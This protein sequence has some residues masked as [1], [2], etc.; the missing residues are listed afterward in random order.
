MSVIIRLQNLP[1]SANALE[2]RTFFRGLNIPDGGVHIVGGEMGDAFIAFSSDEDA[3]Q[4]MLLD[5]GKIN[6]VQIRLLLSSRSEMQKVIELARQQSL[7]MHKKMLNTQTIAPVVVPQTSKIESDPRLRSRNDDDKRR[8]RRSSRDRSHDRYRSSRSSSNERDY[9]DHRRRDRSRSASRSRRDR[10]RSSRRSRSRDRSRERTSDKLKSGES[11][12]GQSVWDLINKKPEDVNPY[13]NAYSTKAPKSNEIDLTSSPQHESENI[14]GLDG[15]IDKNAINNLK[16]L[17]NS[18]PNL[19]SAGLLSALSSLAKP[20]SPAVPSR[21]ETPITPLPPVI[22]AYQTNDNSSGH[23][24]PIMN[25]IPGRSHQNDKDADNDDRGLSESRYTD[26]E[27]HDKRC[28]RISHMNPKTTYSEVRRYFSGLFIQTNGIKLINDDK[29][30]RLGTAYVKFLRATSTP[31]AL[32][33]DGTMLN[34]WKVKVDVVS[35]TEFDVAIDSYRPANKWHDKPREDEN[36]LGIKHTEDVNYDV[37]VL[38]L[39]DLPAYTNELDIKKAFGTNRNLEI[40]LDR[41]KNS[42]KQYGYVK[43]ENSLELKRA[44][45]SNS[46]PRIG[47]HKIDVRKSTEEEMEQLCKAMDTDVLVLSDL[48]AFSAEQDIM[49]LFNNFSII[50][51]FMTR[52][53]PEGKK[54]YE[55][56]SYIKLSNPSDARKILSNRTYTLSHRIIQ[57]RVSNATEMENAKEAHLQKMAAEEAERKKNEEKLKINIIREKQM[58]SNEVAKLPPQVKL[59]QFNDLPPIVNMAP[60]KPASPIE[61]SDPRLR[62][63]ASGTKKKSRFTEPVQPVIIKQEP[64]PQLAPPPFQ[65]LFIG[66]SNIAYRATIIDIGTYFMENNCSPNRI[67]IIKGPNNLPCGDVVLEMKCMEDIPQ[68]LSL[69]NSNFYNRKISVVPITLNDVVNRLGED[70]LRECE[71]MRSPQ[72]CNPIQQY[73]EQNQQP[74]VNQQAF[75]NGPEFDPRIDPRDEFPRDPRARDPRVVEPRFPSMNNFD[76]GG[77]SNNNNQRRGQN[78]FNND[79]IMETPPEIPNDTPSVTVPDKFN[80]PGRVLVL[81]NVPYSASIEDIA[82]FFGNFDV[83]PEDVIRRYNKDGSPTGDARVA[84]HETYLAEAAF[85]QKN[86]Q[87]LFNRILYL[88]PV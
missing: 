77:N 74:F 21:S 78:P 63:G 5:R 72:S 71:S 37:T 29:G 24:Y 82:R 50:D 8:G 7:S 64:P 1:W 88:S 41:E 51:I 86:R 53:K 70:F 27:I 32:F 17:L 2:I 12:Q 66:L 14:P 67:E 75:I 18:N 38:K 49:K 73:P 52:T 25:D 84:F 39:F 10:H 19:T 79:P 43:F 35:E 22:K 23:S 47:N 62:N 30:D 36:N 26:D 76:N 3:R 59:N 87:K 31:K 81:Q 34:G 45:L 48:P 15:I 9:R 60:I 6:E 42:N 44:L 54:E 80:I 40:R 46:C 4:A 55:Y 20:S 83:S 68:A 28:V 57:V 85:E 56:L 69:N 11:S 58:F 13:S 16:N 65:S 33:R 61:N